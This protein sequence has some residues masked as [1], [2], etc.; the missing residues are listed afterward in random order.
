MG[1]WCLQ[2]QNKK[3]WLKP[4]RWD[5]SVY[6]LVFNCQT[7]A[8]PY[9][10]VLQFSKAYADVLTHQSTFGSE[11]HDKRHVCQSFLPNPSCKNSFSHQEQPDQTRK[12]PRINRP[13]QNVVDPS[14]PEKRENTAASG[15]SMM[16]CQ[17][18]EGSG[19]LMVRVSLWLEVWWLNPLKPVKT[20]ETQ[21]LILPHQ[22]HCNLEQ[23]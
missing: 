15:S 5:L 6:H 11:F 13:N 8:K 4:E 3:L 18:T 7:A 9:S 19:G 17:L 2:H 20:S 21:C 10:A 16:G 23:S 14:S 22:H 12:G 1:W